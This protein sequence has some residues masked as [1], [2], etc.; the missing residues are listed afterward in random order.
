MHEIF[1]NTEGFPYEVFRYRETKQFWRKIVIPAPSR[2]PNIF[3][4]PETFWNTDGFLDKIFLHCE[5]KI[6]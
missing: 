6:F 1:W 3:S 4:I 2:F 5:K